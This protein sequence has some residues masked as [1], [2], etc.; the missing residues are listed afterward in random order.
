MNKLVIVLSLTI[1][2]FILQPLAIVQAAAISDGVKIFNA[3]C[4]AC[5]VAGNNIIVNS[6]TLKKEALER[7]NM[8]SLDAIKA[9]VTNGKNAMPAF[10]SRLNETQIEA[11]AAFVL[12]QAAKGW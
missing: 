5:H 12:N 11:V 1:A 7:Y 2:I 9:Q 3:N 6:K 10:K 4:S 8:Y